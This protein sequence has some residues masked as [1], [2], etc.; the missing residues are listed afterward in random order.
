MADKGYHFETDENGVRVEVDH[1]TGKRTPVDELVR[2]AVERGDLL[3]MEQA[4]A[5]E[6]YGRDM[7]KVDEIEEV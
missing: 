1:K 4:M 6:H 5:N 7:R 3:T 2:Q